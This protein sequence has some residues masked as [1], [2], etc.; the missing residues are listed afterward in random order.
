MIAKAK[1]FY[2]AECK[3]D[4]NN[5]IGVLYIYNLIDEFGQAWSAQFDNGH[6]VKIVKT[7]RV[8]E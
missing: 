3:R 1:R 6:F 4:K 8:I 2:A 7:K 5:K